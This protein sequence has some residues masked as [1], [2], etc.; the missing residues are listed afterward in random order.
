[1]ATTEA[2]D[3]LVGKMHEERRALLELLPRLSEEEA[4]H[5]PPDKTGEDGWSVK[6]QLS[7]LAEMEVGYGE[8]REV[9]LRWDFRVL[10]VAPE[11]CYVVD[12][13]AD[14]EAP[15]DRWFT[16]SGRL[17]LQFGSSSLPPGS[18]ERCPEQVLGQFR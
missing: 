1:M 16:A 15:L 6:E 17:R 8:T 12:V 2:I 18:A 13:A 9:R 11:S 7:H 4:E 5:R 10:V 3:D 14:P